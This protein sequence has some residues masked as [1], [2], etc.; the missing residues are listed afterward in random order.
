MI[1]SKGMEENGHFVIKVCTDVEAVAQ[2]A[3]SLFIELYKS[4]LRRSGRFSLVLSGGKSPARTYALL[5]SESLKS[6]IDWSHVHF[7][8]GDERSV[9]V[10]D[11]RSNY[12]EAKRDF[13]S[14]I[15][16]PPQNVH[17]MVL[18]GETGADPQKYASR[19]EAT[20]KRYFASSPPRFDLIFLGLGTNG[21]TASLFPGSFALKE[22][23]RWAVAVKN[24]DEEF[25]RLTLTPHLL[26]NA[27]TIVFLVTGAEKANI[28]KDVIDEVMSPE[29]L[30]A[31]L[32]QPVNGE[33]VWIVDSQVRPVVN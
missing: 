30:P 6:H 27:M 1:Y 28:F 15:P 25:S 29:L 14:R 16:I 13:L 31:R 10:H 21:H 7:F 4:A 26:N 9:E 17:P 22:N 24:D 12:G 5:S 33:L 18:P 19:Y 8:W 20:I 32:I 23:V 3:A 11:K 2:T